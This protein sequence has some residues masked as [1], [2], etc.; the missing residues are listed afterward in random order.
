MSIWSSAGEETLGARK[1]LRRVPVIC[2]YLFNCRL[3]MIDA[4]G[5]YGYRYLISPLLYI[6]PQSL[7][8]LHPTLLSTRLSSPQDV[9]ERW[10]V[11]RYPWDVYHRRIRV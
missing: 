7:K 10:A 9:E 1:E 6:K 5:E 2:C 11:V 4:I 3:W 8:V